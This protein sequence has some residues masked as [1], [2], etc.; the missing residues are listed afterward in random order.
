VV[1]TAPNDLDRVL[2]LQVDPGRQHLVALEIAAMAVAANL[3]FGG[4]DTEDAD[5]D[6]YGGG[7][8]FKH[9]IVL[10]RVTVLHS[11]PMQWPQ[12]NEQCVQKDAQALTLGV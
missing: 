9:L 7:Y 2:G 8:D 6:Q 5:A 10:P 11:L 1:A 12:S 3:G 4:R